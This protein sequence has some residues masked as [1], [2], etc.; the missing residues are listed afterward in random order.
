MSCHIII[1]PGISWIAQIQGIISA[2]ND[3]VIILAFDVDVW[4]IVWES[5]NRINSYPAMVIYLNFQPLE[6]V[7]RYRDPQFQVHMTENYSY[8]SNLNTNIHACPK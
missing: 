7:C 6:I 4:R 1:I 3:F 5:V 2:N 8:L